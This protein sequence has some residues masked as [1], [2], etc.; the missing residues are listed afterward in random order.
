M[1]DLLT[2]A[3]L[4]FADEDT[5]NLFTVPKFAQAN[6][7]FLIIVADPKTDRLFVGHKGRFVNGRIRSVRG[8]ATH[9]IR[10]VIK[11][12]QFNRGPMDEFIGSLADVLKVSLPDANQFYQMID[13][14]VFNIAKSIRTARKEKKAGRRAERPPASAAIPSPIEVGPD[15]ELEGD[16]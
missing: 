2:K 4:I 6:K 1:S 11:R 3:R 16:I 5:S 7:E 8:R 13:G 12:S 15:G 9:V 10:D 14:F